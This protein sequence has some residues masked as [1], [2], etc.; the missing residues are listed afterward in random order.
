MPAFES[1]LED[2]AVSVDIPLSRRIRWDIFA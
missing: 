2:R 1:S